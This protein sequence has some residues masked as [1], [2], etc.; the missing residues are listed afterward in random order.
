MG[1]VER[2]QHASGAHGHIATRCYLVL[3]PNSPQTLIIANLRYVLQPV[4]RLQHSLSPLKAKQ[5]SLLCFSAGF[6]RYTSPHL[7]HHLPTQA[8]ASARARV[9]MSM[10][11]QASSYPSNGAAGL[12]GYMVPRMDLHQSVLGCNFV[13][14][15]DWPKH[16]KRVWVDQYGLRFGFQCHCALSESKSELHD[17]CEFCSPGMANRSHDLIDQ[18]WRGLMSSASDG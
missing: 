17:R 6:N 13:A 8:C 9:A 7:S 12:V 1:C 15:D 10:S 18:D 11:P 16:Q 4:Q 3:L 14:C 2:N 5:S